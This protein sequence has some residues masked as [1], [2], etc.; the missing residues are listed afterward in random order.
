M[1]LT[2]TLLENKA[3][4]GD[5]IAVRY[6]LED[7]SYFGLL[8]KTRAA[9]GV[10]GSLGISNG[11][12][13]ALLLPKGLEFIEL[14]LAVLALGAVVLPLNP[15]Y[16][17]E[18]IAYF[19]FDSE[20]NL[21]ITDQEKYD[22]LKNALIGFPD[23]PVLSIDGECPNCL[24]YRRLLQQTATAADLPYPTREED[25]ALLCYTSGTTG[26]S[27]G[28]MIT[29]GNLIHNLQALHQAWHWSEK[30]VLLHALPLFHIHGLVVA[31]H[32]CLLA[33]GTLILLDRFDP[34]EVWKTIERESCTV[35]MG[36]PTMYQRLSQAWGGLSRKPE[37]KSLR[38]FVSGS[39]PL[40]EVLFQR[41]REQTGHTILE[42]Y[43][44]TE[45][46]M[47]ASN[48]F[49]PERRKA[50]SVGYPLAGVQI[51]IVDAAGRDV[52]S[53]EVGEVRIRGNTL[54]K[55][56][57]R[58]AEKTAE[59]FRD[60]WFKSGDL[61]YRDPGDGGRLFLVGRAK[62][63][64]ISGGLNVY[65]KEV[66]NVLETREEVLEAAVYGR[67]DEDLGEKVLAAVVLRPGAVLT[68]EDCLAHCRRHLAP[69]KCPKKV[70]L[71]PALPRNAMGKIQKQHLPDGPSLPAGLNA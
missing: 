30:D 9:A 6:H 68:P 52:R 57:W 10:L 41:F 56:Y 14:H 13:V 64:I 36:V 67:P 35:F 69:Y 47:I 37:L 4:A 20:T 45:A 26:R 70:T 59:A 44:M 5:K 1:N 18:E 17:P 63:L 51:R 62:E 60:G 28:A 33:G 65:P 8:Q 48:P 23:V 25:L 55:G 40:S 3:A 27:K 29:H 21:L 61:G 58:Q 71:L 12:R 22:E 54:F 38:L 43:G 53:G 11:D 7:L 2:Q 31:L 16:R 49:D 42:R 50:G 34:Q 46:G 66:E 19:L 15:G 39:A 24:S 32:G